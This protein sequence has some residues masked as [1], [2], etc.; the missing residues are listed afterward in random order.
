MKHKPQEILLLKCYDAFFLVCCGCDTS[1]IVSVHF[2]YQASIYTLS[3]CHGHSW[4]VRLAKQ[5]TLTPPGHLVSPLVC[6]GPWIS[7]AVLYCRCHS[8]SASV[9]LYLTSLYSNKFPFC[10]SIHIKNPLR[11]EQCT[12]C[13]STHAFW[14]L[15]NVGFFPASLSR[16]FSRL[17][18]Q[19]KL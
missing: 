13:E 6:R 4:R 7:T 5:E 9:L 19:F 18:R 10:W 1:Y 17:W 15:C 3:L 2:Q 12:G 16:H 14:T 8:E 11:N